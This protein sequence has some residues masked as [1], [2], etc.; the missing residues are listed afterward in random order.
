MFDALAFSE[1]MPLLLGLDLGSTTAKLA[2]LEGQTIL[3]RR[4]ER[5]RSKV[6]ETTLSLLDDLKEQ[7]GDRP[8]SVALSGSAGLGLSQQTNLPFVQEVYATGQAVN[9]LAPE[10]DAVVELGGEDAKVLFLKGGV[11]Q[12]MN[13]SCAGGTGAF[14]DQMATLLG[15]TVEQLDALSL[16]HERIYPIASRCGVFAKSDIQPLLNQGARRE[17]LAASIYQAVVNQT[18]TGLAQ[19]R[20]I[21]GRVLFL[22][23]PLHYCKGLRQRF[24]ETLHLSDDQALF[25]DYGRFA[26]AIGA[27]LCAK[28]QPAQFT[29]QTLAQ[30]LHSACATNDS[31]RLP[32]LFE[33]EQDYAAFC[34]RHARAC[35]TQA[36]EN[37][38]GDAYLGIDCGST[39]TKLALLTAKGELLYSYYGSSCGNPVDMV[40]RQLE[41]VYARCGQSI[42]IRGSAVTGYGE[43]LIRDA[44]HVGCGVVETMAHLTAARFFCPE[45]DF[46]LDIGGQDIKCFTIKDGAIDAISLNEACSSGCG[47]FLQT[48]ATSMGMS[49]EDFAKEGLFAASPV[50]LGSRCTVFMNSSVKQAQKEGATLADISAGLSIS[51][52]KNALY[53]VIR[54]GSPPVLG[55][56][57]VAQ[58]GTFLNDAVLRAFEREL[59]QEVLRPD[60]AGLM[61]AVG[62]AL[63][64]MRHESD[65]LLRGEALCQFTHRTT[66]AQC[67]G[68]ANHCA[69]TISH[70]A[71]GS[72]SISGNRCERALGQKEEEHGLPNLYEYKRRRMETLCAAPGERGVIGLALALGMWD[73]APLWHG[74]FSALG[75]SVLL[76][77]PSTRATYEKG[78]YSIPSDT[79]CYPAKLMHG[80]MEELLDQKPDFI[81]CPCLTYNLE[82]KGGDNHYNCPVVAYYP[83]LLHGNLPRLNQTRFLYP[84][85]NLNSQRQLAKE[86]RAMFAQQGIAFSHAQMH[87]AVQQG[88]AAHR[89][90]Q[91]DLS[92]EGERALAYA[93]E[94][95][96]RVM[97]LAGRPYHVDPEIGHGIDRLASS[98]GFVV[99]SEDSVSH[100][101]APQSVDVLNQW[102]YHARL[103]RAAAFAAATPGV[104]LVQLV[105]FGCGIDAITTDEVRAILSAKGKLY[106]GIK[107]DEITNLGAV[108]IRLRSLLAALEERGEPACQTNTPSSPGR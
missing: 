61:G 37:Y 75:F 74:I 13:G 89:A 40:R 80:H 76:S 39:T 3:Y 99:V 52:V 12:R 69:L 17:D 88:Y 19:G 41:L 6:R 98:L 91:N 59:G 28:D 42:R 32:P 70:F 49:I 81:F 23:G 33:S 84:Y 105:S 46:I 27:A 38:E 51:V 85:L 48:F 54:A 5:H 58:G 93:G 11:D 21:E 9:A 108:R 97:I 47:S 14:I 29:C 4:Y 10:A 107:I 87:H 50:D 77:A 102:T 57:V 8:F 73:L 65:T 104:E 55:K 18:I 86:L 36:P 1:H 34:A 64:A 68:C 103:Y 82:E 72:R 100:L 7:I 24:V 45:V 44:F 79:V 63:Y 78:Q 30:A 22:G 2:L 96:K 35:L 60:V 67:N 101:A 92:S 94:H 43:Q 66:S 83:E 20:A 56:H 71:D 31:P 26:V 16:A 62:A 90:W 106:T 53:K 25:P 95:Q 15:V